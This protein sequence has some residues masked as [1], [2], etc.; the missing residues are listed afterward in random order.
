MEMEQSL[1]DFHSGEGQFIGQVIC[2]RVIKVYGL[3]IPQ[4]SKIPD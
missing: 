2:A 4:L 1:V 3:L